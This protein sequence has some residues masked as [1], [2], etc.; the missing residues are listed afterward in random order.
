MIFG[1]CAR[2]CANRVGFYTI[3]Y[4]QAHILALALLM[5]ESI[6]F[7]CWKESHHVLDHFVCDGH[8]MAVGWPLDGKYLYLLSV[9]LNI[10]ALIP[11]WRYFSTIRFLAVGWNIESV[12]LPDEVGNLWIFTIGLTLSGCQPHTS[13]VWPWSGAPKVHLYNT[14]LGGLRHTFELHAHAIRRPWNFV[15]IF[16]SRCLC[17]DGEPRQLLP[18]CRNTDVRSPV[19]HCLKE[20]VESAVILHW[21][22]SCL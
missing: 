9:W 14:V 13:S 20:V 2:S 10:I 22:T 11:I 16:H 4:I 21:D 12:N 18:G 8:W 17:H 5:P 6:N 3:P 19:S 15:M 1:L 7:W